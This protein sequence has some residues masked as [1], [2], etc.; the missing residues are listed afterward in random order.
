MY[1]K[2]K[3]SD[4]PETA[5]HLVLSKHE[6]TAVISVDSYRRIPHAFALA[7]FDVLPRKR[8]KNASIILSK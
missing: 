3:D 5:F 6:L 4:F 2:K 7:C 1:K 8:K